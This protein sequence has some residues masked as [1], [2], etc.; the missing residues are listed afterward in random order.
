MR[1][2]GF[3]TVAEDAAELRVP[4]HC[5]VVASRGAAAG[6]AASQK[7]QRGSHACFRL[8][9]PT[10]TLWEAA[11]EKVS[12]SS[13]VPR[14]TQSPQHPC[15]PVNYPPCPSTWSWDMSPSSECQGGLPQRHQCYSKVHGPFEISHPKEPPESTFF[16]SQPSGKL[17]SPQKLDIFLILACFQGQQS[18]S[19]ALPVVQHGRVERCHCLC[20]FAIPLSV[21]H[22]WLEAELR[23]LAPSTAAA[24]LL[25][26]CSATAVPAKPPQCH[27][28]RTSGWSQKLAG[29]EWFKGQ[30]QKSWTWPGLATEPCRLLPAPSLA[31]LVPWPWP[32]IA[33]TAQPPLICWSSQSLQLN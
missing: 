11:D 12:S 17:S 18:R 25:G 5:Y 22:G 15:P 10:L 2:S 20:A 28:Q 9:T 24:R 31:I 16:T 1:L 29:G 27:H 33:C 19:A 3:I 13:S 8:S 6:W 14:R 7:G 4:V 23:E 21:L 32:C 30:T 26:G